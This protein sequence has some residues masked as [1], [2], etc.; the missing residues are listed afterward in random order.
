MTFNLL[1]SQG[2]AADTTKYTLEGAAVTARAIQERFGPAPQTLGKPSPPA[3]DSW[4]ESLPQAR[5]ALE[6]VADAVEASIRSGERTVLVSNTCSISLAS[7]PVMARHFPDAM[8]L[9]IDAHGD[10]NTPE[11]TETGYLGGMVVAAVCGLW[12]SGHGA[13]L[14]PQ[15]VLFV[16]SRDVDAEEELLINRSGARILPADQVTLEALLAVVGTRKL[17]IHID[18]DV[19]EP[20]YVPADYAVSGGLVPDQIRSIL[21]SLPQNQVLGLEIAEFQAPDDP[22]QRQRAVDAILHMIEPILGNPHELSA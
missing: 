21:A 12:D 3:R 16:G 18:W 19:L 2:R 17:W 22:A 13:G 11:T 7:L 20:G 15:N 1:V 8:L 9:W 6:A 14:A 4:T 5:P 10:F